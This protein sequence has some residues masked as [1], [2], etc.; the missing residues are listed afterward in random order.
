VVGCVVC[1][2]EYPFDRA[3]QPPQ[4]PPQR[5][6]PGYQNEQKQRNRKPLRITRFKVPLCARWSDSKVAAGA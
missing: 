3:A 6:M 2:L 4:L 1:V 5:Q